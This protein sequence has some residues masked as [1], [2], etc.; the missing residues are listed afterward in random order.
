VI[1]VSDGKVVMT[2][3]STRL[4]RYIVLQDATGNTYTYA[5]LGSIPGLYPVPRPL[6]TSQVARPLLAPSAPKPTGPA[7]AGSQQAHPTVSTARM[8][9]QTKKS[10]T[11]SPPATPAVHSQPAATIAM[12]MV[13]ERLFAHPSR[14]A[15]YA[16]G[17]RPQIEK[18]Q[19]HSFQ[20]YFSSALHLTKNQYA[21]K[22]L[23]AG[24]VIVAGTILGRMGPGTPG[25]PSHL[26]F[27]IQ[28]AGKDAPYIDPTPVLDGWK[29]LKAADIYRASRVDPPFGPG[30]KN[31]TVGQIL[32]MSKEQL[33]RRVLSDPNVQIYPCGQRDIRAGSIDRRV[34]AVI[35]F[36]SSSGLKPYI[37]GLK[38]GSRANGSSGV[39]VAGS[40]GAS[41]DI[42]AVNGIPILGHQGPGS[43][44]DMTIRRLLTLQGAMEP[45]QIVSLMSYRGQPTTL[46]L[47]DHANRIQISYAPLYGPNT[48]ASA[49]IG[50]ILDPRQW[51]QLINRV[52]RIPEPIVP[53][54]PSKYAIKTPGP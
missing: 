32:L 48:K 4:G 22:P 15:S 37:S 24:S 50:S 40:T 35:E 44:T 31:A 9:R 43:I 51:S 38:C 28:P 52:S 16:A 7:T 13:K 17:G 11:I 54:S 12:P 27:M 10:A 1:A 39:D 5:N 49:E 20:T 36:L 42:S 30:V 45:D 53:V 33:E 3:L 19:L 41:V 46:S 29:L 26:D 21:L 6:S 2:G 47:A 18:P 8:I 23:K 25:D 14:P 34:L